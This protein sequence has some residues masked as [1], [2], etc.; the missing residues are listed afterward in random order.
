MSTLQ[1]CQLYSGR[2][3]QPPGVLDFEVDGC[4][5]CEALEQDREKPRHP[6]PQVRLRDLP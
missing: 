2:G 4:R 5:P 1:T 3:Q 6:P